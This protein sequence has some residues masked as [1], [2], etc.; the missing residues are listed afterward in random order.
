M[1]I[2]PFRSGGFFGRFVSAWQRGARRTKAGM[3]G[4]LLILAAAL[5]GAGIATG[6]AIGALG[7]RGSAL[8]YVRR[9]E[10]EMSQI[11]A[12]RAPA[13]PGS[14]PRLEL[15]LERKHLNAL[16]AQRRAAL[17]NRILL[18]DA[19][20]YVPAV[21]RVSGEQ[22]VR[23]ARI[24]LKGDWTDHLH[25]DR[26]SFRLEMAGEQTVLGMKRFSLQHP[27]T[28]A[29]LNEWVFH[30]ALA[31]EDVLALRYRFVAVSLNGTELG[32]YAVEEHFDKRLP[33]HRHRR[34]G[35]IV[36]FDE[37][38]FWQM[39]ARYRAEFP[40]PEARA[41]WLREG[42][43]SY[44]ASAVDAFKTATWQADPA[45]RA[46]HE[47]AISLLESFRRGVLKASEV[48]DV[49][50]TA[51]YFALT[52]LLG[53]RHASDWHNIR[54]YYNPVTSRLEPI[55][56]DAN[57][58]CALTRLT[59]AQG[60]A[61]VGAETVPLDYHYKTL[62]SDPVLFRSYA[63]HLA[64]ISRKSYVDELFAVLDKDLR[65]NEALLQ[66]DWPGYRFKR[67][68]YYRNAAYIRAQ[69][70][71]PEAMR[72]YLHA[73]HTNE[74]ELEFGNLQSLPV[75]VL[76]VA[77]AR[78]AF[79][80]PVGLTLAGRPALGMV[81]YRNFTARPHLA[82]DTGSVTN[83]PCS[84]RYRLLGTA[85]IR[86]TS[87]VPWP[88]LPAPSTARDVVRRGAA[89]D[90]PFI[91]RNTD[92]RTIRILPGTWRVATDLLVPAG[93]TLMCG[94]NTTLELDDGA[95]IL[96]CSP[97]RFTGTREHPIT[98]RAGANGGQGL[99]V[100]G[101]AGPSELRWVTFQG[102][103]APARSGWGI[104][105][106]VTFYE[107]PVAI[108]WCRF[109]DSRAED[110]LNVIRSPEFSV[111]DCVFERAA[112]DALD[113]D[114]S[115]GRVASTSFAECGNDAL[116]MS[117]SVVAVSELTVRGAQDKGLS[118]GEDSLLT[119]TRVEVRGAGIGLAAKDSS[120]A[121]LSELR[122]MDCRVGIAVLRKKPEF[123]PAFVTLTDAS[124]EGRARKHLVERGSTLR[125]NG[126]DMPARDVD[127]ARRLYG[128]E[129]AVSDD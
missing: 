6:W 106:A 103:S 17:P 21:L 52:D 51:R 25:G 93:D 73:A 66:R 46:Q 76:D 30:R 109:T 19:V 20:A 18:S 107:T 77:N 2:K 112:F 95:L 102:L 7:W 71:P 40:E 55:G 36:R 128:R 80:V 48:F 67:A 24:R 31:R 11:A 120:T 86:T 42:P 35:P 70:D 91:A 50:R 16:I 62:F 41:V 5:F 9:F 126:V 116:D 117:G 45:R 39:Q 59:G 53:A 121:N 119:G 92:T 85:R 49:D 114:F 3:L 72:A 111:E 32:L 64:R 14:V 110:S 97:V 74:F 12:S 37:T 129:G 8:R 75:E 108:T 47:K 63:S 104:T 27:Q 33:E 81:R 94:P 15:V 118:V 4:L 23:A 127:V 96:S 22:Q 122:V 29:Y 34:E 44:L 54:F 38:V 125:L 13:Y 123:G 115:K 60:S 28:R 90:F 65:R 83:V 87:V 61:Y 84:V 26:W 82:L 1:Q 69:L 68:V 78:P 99:V 113:V 98:I 100:L 105:G 56:F 10:G 57:A 58:G 124:I 101:G 89:L 88:H 43:G 79:T